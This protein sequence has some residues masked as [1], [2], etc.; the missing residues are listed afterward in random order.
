MK[1]LDNVLY[2]VGIVGTFDVE[3][4]GDL[5]F[6]IIAQRQLSRRLKNVKIVPF[7]PN[8]LSKSQPWPIDVLSTDA[9]KE[10]LPFLSGL[11]IGGGQIVRFD[12]GYPIP[13][14][15]NINIPIDYWLMPAVLGAILGKPVIWN[16]LGAWTG[17]SVPS[18]YSDVLKATLSASALVAVRDEASLT[19][20]DHIGS[21]A[22]IEL[23]PDTAFSLAALW[24]NSEFSKEFITWRENLKLETSYIVLQADKHFESYLQEITA[25]LISLEIKTVVILPVCR[26]HGDDSQNFSSLAPFNVIRSDWLD[27][28]LT[29]EVIKH[30]NLVIASSLHACITAICYGVACVRV[31]SFNHSDRKFEIVNNFNNICRLNE[32]DRIVGLYRKGP[33]VDPRAI[34]YAKLLEQYWDR[35][36][37]II[38][39]WKAPESANATSIMLPV[40]I[41]LLKD[42]DVSELTQETPKEK[43]SIWSMLRH[44]S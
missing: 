12:K 16:A 31:D 19:H 24:P 14:N 3:N 7:S 9:I 28:I 15:S 37:E 33:E 18:S 40:I 10:Q 43:R 35:V 22:K 8:S 21:M 29:C 44:R 34:A 27:P 39:A 20:F 23:T 32:T 30:S 5:L 26:C 13:V 36:A 1:F 25:L 4:Y 38:T 17:S 11:L 41:N 6:P 2:E 42:M